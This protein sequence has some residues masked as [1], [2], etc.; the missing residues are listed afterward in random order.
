MKAVEIAK[1]ICRIVRENYKKHQGLDYRELEEKIVILLKKRGKENGRRRTRR[2][3][4]RK[5]F[6]RS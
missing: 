1:K 3:G 6:R 4:R 2:T 5:L